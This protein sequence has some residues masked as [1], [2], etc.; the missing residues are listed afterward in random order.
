[1]GIKGLDVSLL[2][3]GVKYYTIGKIASQYHVSADA[4]RYYEDVGLIK[5]LRSSSGYRLYTDFDI[6]KLN[7]IINL[8]NLDFSIE[9]IRTYFN[10]GTID[11]TVKLLEEEQ[12]VVDMRLE[13]LKKIKKRIVENLNVINMAQTLTMD[14]ITV[15]HFGDRKAMVLLEEFSKDE[16]MDRLMTQLADKAD[17]GIDI[18]GNRYIA[19]VLAPLDQT[20]H[21]YNGAIMFRDDGTYSIPAGDFLSV[22]YSGK[23]NSREYAKKLIAYASEHGMKLSDTFLDLIWIDIHTAI[24]M[25]DHIS[26]IQVRIIDR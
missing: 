26:E 18:I 15:K 16:E 24:R 17:V 14:E 2:K 12:S 21:I 22:C 5:P 20:D 7:V 25:S 23:W 3:D 8:R 6:W 9:R 1:M 19:A 13:E 11:S 10:E 4:L